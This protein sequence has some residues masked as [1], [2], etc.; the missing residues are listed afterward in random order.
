MISRR[1]FILSGVAFSLYSLA[2]RANSEVGGRG[3]IINAA[4]VNDKNHINERLDK[5]IF[6]RN[7]CGNDKSSQQNAVKVFV[8]VISKSTM[9][10]LTGCKVGLCLSD[11]FKAKGKITSANQ[12]CN[13]AWAEIK[14]EIPI[15]FRTYIPKL[16]LKGN[17]VMNP[18]DIIIRKDNKFGIYRFNFPLDYLSSIAVYQSSAKEAV[19]AKTLTDKAIE[20]YDQKSNNSIV[21]LRPEFVDGFYRVPITFILDDV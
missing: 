8:S 13:V 19:T 3:I 6:S 5:F 4:L 16:A 18:M 21:E 11:A 10:S 7:Q 15:E 20:L 2:C 17:K 12:I 9:Q 1:E 14:D